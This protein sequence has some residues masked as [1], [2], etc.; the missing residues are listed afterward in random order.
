VTLA[1]GS[2]VAG[3]VL[4]LF[5]RRTPWRRYP[6]YLAG[7]A[8]GLGGTELG[9][10]LAATQVL[11][12]GLA[13]GMGAGRSRVGAAGLAVAA[14]TAVGLVGLHRQSSAAADVLQ[15][16]IGEPPD[17]VSRVGKPW[18]TRDIRYHDD[19][20]EQR[21]DIW[22]GAATTGAPVMIYVH[23]GSWVAGSKRGQGTHLITELT[24]RGWL[25]VSID[26][27]L[28]PRNRWPSMIVDVKRAIAWVRANIASY[29][30]DPS[31]VAIAGG[32]AGAHLAALAAL[33]ANDPRFQPGFTEA[34]TSIQAAALLYGVYDLTAL[35]DD[36]QPRLRDYV[37]RVLFDADLLD[38]ET[39]WR[40]ASPTWRVDEHAPPMFVV[41]GDRDEIVSV[42]QARNFVARARKV[43]RIAYAELPYAHHAFDLI[44]SARTKATVRA[45]GQFL[46]AAR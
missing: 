46:D 38:D 16:A 9:A 37:R 13:I 8:T 31:F 28:G 15:R 29:G 40:A 30:G 7:M 20:A 39:T 26:Y 24:A 41:H 33:S 34:D 22:R 45:V 23:G 4:N 1:V 27:R 6:W 17:S 36:G 42:T 25:C 19:S 18:V 35:N 44:G 3:V 5:G 2:A 32:S 14:G 43:T 12:G 10:P 11:A 21:L